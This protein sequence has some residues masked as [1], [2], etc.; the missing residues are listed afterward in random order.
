[1]LRTSS[2]ESR[3][4]EYLEAEN[5][6]DLTLVEQQELIDAAGSV[7]YSVYVSTTLNS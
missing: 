1:M 6:P 3:I 4:K 5:L 7:Y 2:K